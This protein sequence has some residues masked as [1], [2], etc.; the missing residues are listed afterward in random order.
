[1]LKELNIEHCITPEQPAEVSI[2][3]AG[4][5]QRRCWLGRSIRLARRVSNRAVSYSMAWP[6]T[7]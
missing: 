3:G 2:A 7:S 6:S 4:G 5:V 1:V